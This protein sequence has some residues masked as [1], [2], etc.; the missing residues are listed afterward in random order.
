[1]GLPFA[2]PGA[3]MPCFGHENGIASEQCLRCASPGCL[4]CLERIDGV[5]YC[6]NCLLRRLQEVEV[7]VYRSQATEAAKDAQLEAKRRVRRNWILTATL[8]LFGVPVAANSV[9]EDNAFP[10][11]L[12][13]FAVPVA[14]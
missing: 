6:T 12:K 2:R 10:S 13:L 3:F 4:N 5:F 11:A 9:I 1:M 8:T 14:A 7:E